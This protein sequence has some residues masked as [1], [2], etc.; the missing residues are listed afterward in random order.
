MSDFEIAHKLWG[1]AYNRE[2][3]YDYVVVRQDSFLLNFQPGFKHEV[4]LPLTV[5]N[6]Q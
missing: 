3:H 2:V 6:G 1:L 5:S 4:M